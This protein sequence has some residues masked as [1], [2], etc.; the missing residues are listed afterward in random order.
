MGNDKF[1]LEMVYIDKG[2]SYYEEGETELSVKYYRKALEI[3]PN[4]QDTI[5]MIAHA[6]LCN[7]QGKKAIEWFAKLIDSERFN[8]NPANYVYLGMAYLLE[9][10]K[11]KGIICSL[12]GIAL[13]SRKSKFEDLSDHFT[14]LLNQLISDGYGMHR[15]ILALFLLWD[16]TTEGLH[17]ISQ[18]Y[19]ELPMPIVFDDPDWFLERY[20]S[21]KDGS[22]YFRS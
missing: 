17:E 7:D 9:R 16:S 13:A 21:S 18:L 19:R 20:F 3:N 22:S 8:P 4:N 5:Y 12:I 11:D 15:I 2:F 14:G 1:S 10:Q 6:Y